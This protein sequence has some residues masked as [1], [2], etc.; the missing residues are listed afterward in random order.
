MM[1]VLHFLA[2]SDRRFVAALDGSGLSTMCFP[3]HA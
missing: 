3:L 2:S 1:E